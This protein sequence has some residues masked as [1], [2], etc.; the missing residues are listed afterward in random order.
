MLDYLKGNINRKEFYD[1]VP[2]DIIKDVIKSVIH[3]EIGNDT[4]KNIFQ[5]IDLLLGDQKLDLIVGGP[6]C[7]TYSHIGRARCP[8]RMKRDPA[9]Q[10]ISLLR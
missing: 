3:A 2:D 8:N 1:L 5:Q 10:S 9:E 4:L 7:Q 6:P